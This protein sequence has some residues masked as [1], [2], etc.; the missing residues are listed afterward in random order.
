MHLFIH[1]FVNK[2]SYWIRNIIPTLLNFGKHE[3]TLLF[4]TKISFS[5]KTRSYMSICIIFRFNKIVIVADDSIMRE[6]E[7]Q[8]GERELRQG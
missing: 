6:M 1:N 4:Y 7:W 3:W 8:S 2:I 5:F